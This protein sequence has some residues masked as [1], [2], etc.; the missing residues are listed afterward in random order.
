[1]DSKVI[2]VA[3]FPSKEIDTASIKTAGQFIVLAQLV[4]PITQL[5]Q[6]GQ[7]QGDLVESWK[8]QNN[9]T[10]FNFKIKND[11]KWSDGSNITAVD[12]ENSFKRQIKLNTSNHFD[13]G[14]IKKFMVINQLEFTIE[15]NQSNSLFIRQLSYPEFGI[16]KIEENSPVFS[17]TSGPYSLIAKNDSGYSLTKNHHY[18]DFLEGS[19]DKINFH[20]YSQEEILKGNGKNLDFIIPY[21]LT[22]NEVQDLVKNLNGTITQPHIGFT[23]WFSINPDSSLFDTTKK[24]RY[25]QNLIKN[26]LRKIEES[27]SLLWTTANQLYLP[28]GLG[29]PTALE[30]EKIWKE[31]DNDAKGVRLEGKEVKILLRPEFRFTREVVKLLENEGLKP[32]ITIAATFQEITRLNQ[33]ENFDLLLMSND[34][35]SMDLHEN[36]QTTFNP[37]H[38]LIITN[39]DDSQFQELLKAALLEGESIQR[40]EVYKDIAKKVLTK[41]YIAPIVYQKLV[42]IHKKNIDL[43][44]WSTLFPDFS[45]W[46]MKVD[47]E[48]NVK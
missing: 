43:S 16:I 30:L 39:K 31:I 23:H 42:F 38:P 10:T 9:F 37:L 15:L 27:T 20:N 17:I 19:P 48:K 41:G 22:E 12:V 24:K 36:L 7:I 14:I 13:F 18:K 29:R 5:D 35:S 2:N 6:Q 34:F 33:N 46:R 25:I 28:D 4:R 45:F 21:A 32:K 26:G 1:M 11:A 44:A 8:I 3:I 47:N 40:H